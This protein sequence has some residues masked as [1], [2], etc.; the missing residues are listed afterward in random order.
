MLSKQKRAC[1]V[2]VAATDGSRAAVRA[3][4]ERL[5]YV[6]C[7]VKAELADALAA[8]SGQGELPT[9]LAECISAS[10]LCVFLL[11]EAGVDDGL[12]GDAAGLANQLGKPILGV[13]VGGRTEYPQ[14]FD[15][16]ARS[17]VREDSDRFDDAACGTEIWEQPDRTPVGGRKIRHIRCQ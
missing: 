15:D 13:V 3:R 6:V 9:E 5:D 14:S 16:H 11:P 12:L 8:Q 2:Y 10:D 7:E 4:L 17:M 1:L